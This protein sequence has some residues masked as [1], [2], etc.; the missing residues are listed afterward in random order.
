MFRVCLTH[1]TAQKCQLFTFHVR[2]EHSGRCV[3]QEVQWL[4]WRPLRKDQLLFNWSWDFVMQTG[5][6]GVL[7]PFL[8]RQRQ[9]DKGLLQLRTPRCHSLWQRS[10]GCRSVRQLTALHLQPASREPW[11][12][13]SA[14][15]LLSGI[16]ALSTV[17]PT[18]RMGFHSSAARLPFWKHPQT[19]PKV[20]FHVDSKS[21]QV[22]NAD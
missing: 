5:Q 18:F 7:V 6:G 11:I 4:G 17:P 16:P 10:P 15:F 13:A 21:S 12:L 22:D 14:C 19:D 8:P 3:F 2:P 20:G 9:R 1:S